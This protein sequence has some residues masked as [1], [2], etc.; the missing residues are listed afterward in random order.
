MT[1]Q[2]PPRMT[3]QSP[4]S[5]WQNCPVEQVPPLLPPQAGPGTQA[6]VVFTVTPATSAKQELLYVVPS[7]P[8][9]GDTVVGQDAGM[10]V[11]TPAGSAEQSPELRLQN[12]PAAHVFPAPPPHTAPDTHS[13][14]CET[15]TPA[16]SARQALSYVIP[17]QPHTGA[18]V[19]AHEVGMFLQT[20]SASSEQT[21]AGSSQNCPVAHVTPVLP[22]QD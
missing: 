2:L 6:V 10:G 4:S 22:P 12:S 15:L 1:V 18:S 7:Q 13:P 19:V 14:V 3:E 9:T 5:G 21:P 8:H 16:A 20:P 11:Q 17:S